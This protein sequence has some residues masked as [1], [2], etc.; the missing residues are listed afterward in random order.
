MM[1]VTYNDF[2]TYSVANVIDSNCVSV[3]FQNN[4]TNSGVVI[5]GFYTLQPGQ[6]IEL[7]CNYGEIDTTKYRFFFTP[8]GAGNVDNLTIVKR[9]YK[10]PAGKKKIYFDFTERTKSGY[11]DSECGDI[12][13][14]NNSG[15]A[16]GI[17]ING[18]FIIY[19]F[20]SISLNINECE[21][22]TTKYNFV[23]AGG[24]SLISF[25]TIIRKMIK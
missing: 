4:G 1:E 8:L 14:Q 16:Q 23:F 17:I 6:S 10:N 24:S 11:I 13:F 15:F 20:Q 25:L 5:N 9:M 3:L 2:S 12:C 22:D 18:C 19:G 7:S 21:I